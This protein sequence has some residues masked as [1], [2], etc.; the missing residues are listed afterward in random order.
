MVAPVFLHSSVGRG[1]VLSQPSWICQHNTVYAHTGLSGDHPCE[2]RAFITFSG[3][4][5]WR[6]CRV[7]RVTFL[8][9]RQKKSFFMTFPV[10]VDR[11][12]W[13]KGM[14]EG[15]KRFPRSNHT[16]LSSTCLPV[17]GGKASTVSLVVSSADGHCVRS[18]L[19]LTDCS[20]QNKAVYR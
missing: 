11:L 20:R 13:R 10:S 2:W 4:G 17:S 9:K 1:C 12:D 19:L 18:T 3:S 5:Y 8:F 16:A 15:W 6:K 14:N 7:T